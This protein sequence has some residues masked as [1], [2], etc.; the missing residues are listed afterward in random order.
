MSAQLRSELLK[1]RTTRTNLGLLLSMV[2]LIAAVVLLH[3]LSLPTENL[4]GREGQLEVFGLGTT[5]GMIFGSLLGALS[6]TNEF[7]HGTIRPTFL[8]T[9]KRTRVIAAKVVASLIAG[10]AFGLLAEA[11]AIGV[12]C[13]GLVS[14]RIQI[15]ANAG[16][17]GQ[18][19][20][21]GAA[22]AALWAAI[23]VGT[24]AIVRNQ[25]GTA[26]GLVVWLL[27]AEMTLIGS[28]PSVGRF[29]P[30]ASAAALAGAMLQHT[31]TYLLAPAVG[32]LL[33]A[34]YAATT[35]G[36]GMLATARR[37]VT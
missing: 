9:S 23:G 5:F 14:R 3:M 35:T 11:I 4:S 8:A 26:V 36:V 37:D 19:L 34:A 15:T 17:F 18:L 21:G 16:D 25:V 31:A 30:G 13:A 22:A 28:L 1:Q 20:V 24:G 6:I 27:F 32:A 29:L 2:A 10:A 7:R 12:G 33:I